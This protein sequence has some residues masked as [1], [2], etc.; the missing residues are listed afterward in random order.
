MF[1]FC[2]KLFFE[3]FSDLKKFL[4]IYAE[5]IICTNGKFDENMDSIISARSNKKRYSINE[6][7]LDILTKHIPVK[8][9]H[10]LI[11]EYKVESFE[12]NKEMET[13]IV[14]CFQNLVD[15]VLNLKL[16]NGSVNSGHIVI[17]YFILLS[18]MPLSDDNKSVVAEILQRLFDNE[19]FI[20]FFFSID[21][22]EW[23]LSLKIIKELVGKISIKNGIEVIKNV[24]LRDDFWNYFANV[25]TYD[26]C[27][28]FDFF[29]K[30]E[31]LESVQRDIDQIINAFEGKKKIHAIRL[32]KSNMIESSSTLYKQYISEHYEDLDTDN[33]FD[34]FYSEWMELSSENVNSLIDKALETYRK[35]IPGYSVWPDPMESKLE[36]IC[37]LYITGA[38]DDLSR[39]ECLKEENMFIQFF[40]EEDSFDFRK[41]DLS[42]YMWENIARRPRF[43]EIL[44]RH[45]EVIIPKIQ[46]RIHLECATEFERI[47]LYGY[48]LDKSELI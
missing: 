19:E 7:D 24:I 48:L 25:N 47:V 42:N 37:L 27:H 2:N 39:L 21:C 14:M 9:F 16:Y 5:A 43:M 32:L 20:G 6:I 35:R 12:T 4:K 31:E 45:K 33:I 22:P 15:S 10:N 11:Q 18:H 26:L 13:Y 29:I 23:R 30:C 1:Y 36:L 28:V 46:E 17:S 41:V 3:N 38:I 8:E 34:F 40:I 44:V